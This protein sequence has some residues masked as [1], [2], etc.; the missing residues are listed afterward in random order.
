MLHQLKS[1]TCQKTFSD[2]ILVFE[3][4]NKK[5]AQLKFPRWELYQRSLLLASCGLFV[6]YL[7]KVLQKKKILPNL[8]L[9]NIFFPSSL[10]LIFS[11]FNSDVFIMFLFSSS[12]LYLLLSLLI[13]RLRSESEEQEYLKR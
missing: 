5:L 7:D 4:W 1:E 10:N 9:S 3:L 6:E 13:N 12:Y 2:H 8:A 11:L